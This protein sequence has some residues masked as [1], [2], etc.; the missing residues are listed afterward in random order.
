MGRTALAFGNLDQEVVL[1]RFSAPM[2]ELYWI[3]T[4]SKFQ[5]GNHCL[6][7]LGSNVPQSAR[8]LINF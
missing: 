4:P 7:N 6:L 8:H 1:Q 2:T 5:E 3:Y